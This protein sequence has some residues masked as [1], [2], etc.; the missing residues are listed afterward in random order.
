ML[1]A[2]EYAHLRNSACA[3]DATR[4]AALVTIIRFFIVKIPPFEECASPA[5]PCTGL[6]KAPRRFLVCPFRDA[7]TKDRRQLFGSRN[8]AAPAGV[9]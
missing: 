6:G 5:T 3:C 8:A 1:A 2:S 9:G 7:V 4:S